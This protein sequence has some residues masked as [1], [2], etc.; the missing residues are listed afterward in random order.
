MTCVIRNLD[1]S[2]GRVESSRERFVLLGILL[3]TIAICFFDRTIVSVLAASDSFLMEMHIKGDPVSIG[4]MMSSFLVIYGISNIVISP[5]GDVHGPRKTM[6]VSIALWF[7]AMCAGALAQS[8]YMIIVSRIILGAA[9]GIHYPMTTVYVKRWF[10]GCERG[11]ANAVWLIGQS[12]AQAMAMPVFAWVLAGFSWR[13]GF[14]AFAVIGLI[15]L[16]L[17]WWQT[18][19][20]P[21]Q[22]KRVSAAEL[23]LIEAGLEPGEAVGSSSAKGAFWQNVG[24][25]A[26]N[27]RYW[28][29]VLWYITEQHVFWGLV[30]WLPSYLKNARHFSWE[31]MGWLA[32]L[33]FIC[34]IVAKIIAGWGSDYL[35][36]RAPFCF[37]GMLACGCCIY[38]AATVENNMVSAI[39]VSIAMGGALLGTAMAWTI[40]QSM[41]PSRT[42]STAA[43][44]MNGTANGLAALSPVMIGFFMALT[45]SYTG[46]LFFIV[47]VSFVG[48]ATGLILTVQ[49]Y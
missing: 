32:S 9:Q 29:L 22:H 38:F 12:L 17:I 7:V 2:S 8:F 48:A 45:G 21:R 33:P 27:Y 42:I 39:L 44:L 49:K 13:F 30:A 31:Q 25:F 6:A 46:G 35:G 15:P 10:P 3:F 28:L 23:R 19:D 5:L 1:S 14:W 37:V 11:R 47:G 16:Y 20:T 18:T 34:G 43:G 24:A 36:R 41:V 26:K 40:L 4:L